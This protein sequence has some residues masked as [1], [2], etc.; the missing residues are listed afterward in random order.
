MLRPDELPYTMATG[1]VLDDVTPVQ[2]MEAVLAAIDYAGLRERQVKARAQGRWLGVGL[3]NVVESTT[4]GSKFYKSA[5]IAGSGHE[6]AWLRIEPSGVVNASVGLGA[7][8]QGYETALAN[9]VADGLGVAPASVKLHLGHTDIAPYGMGSRG[10]RGGT[11]GGGVLYLC[12]QQARAAVLAIGAHL[13][14]LRDAQDLRL[15][16][17]R[18]Q[19]CLAGAWSDTRLGLTDARDGGEAGGERVAPDG[20]RRVHAAD[21]L[22]PLE[23]QELEVLV[24]VAAV[25]DQLLQEG[26]HLGRIVLVRPAGAGRARDLRRGL[27]PPPTRVHVP[28][29]PLPAHRQPQHL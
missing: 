3:C 25:R 21:D 26:H 7:T 20:G 16:D 9:A 19:Q 18:I 1:E 11:A 17:S 10:A 28:L 24:V 13:L 8:G 2:T 27:P 5:G 22:H 6:A 4:Y 12:A 29:E 15:Q 14:G 23:P